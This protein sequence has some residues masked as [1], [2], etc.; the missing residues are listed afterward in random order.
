M[1]EIIGLLEALAI[2]FLF[3]LILRE[4][5]CWYWKINHRF[6]ELKEIN[7]KLDMILNNSANDRKYVNVEKQTDTRK[8]EPDS[9]LEKWRSDS[10]AAKKTE[11]ERK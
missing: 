5:W 9:I 1:Y 8:V 2:I 6:T 10:L 7:K 4:F 3:M 11:G